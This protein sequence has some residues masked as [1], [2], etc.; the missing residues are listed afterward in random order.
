MQSVADQYLQALN[1][2]DGAAVLQLFNNSGTVVSPIY[3]NR[4]A[5]DFYTT[6]FDDTKSSQTEL[7]QLVADVEKGSMVLIFAYQ[8]LLNDGRSINF[9]V[10]D[11]IEFDDLGKI[12]K[13]VIYYDTYPL[14]GI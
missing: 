5:A 6:L 13:L 9:E 2:G 11:L 1:H 3:G 14:R 8:W 12:E 7:I 4:A 10:A